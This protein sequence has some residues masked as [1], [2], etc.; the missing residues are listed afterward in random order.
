M[1]W[2]ADDV[3][4]VFFDAPVFTAVDD[5]L[6]VNDGGDLRLIGWF[7]DDFVDAVNGSREEFTGG[8]SHE[9]VVEGVAGEGGGPIAVVVIGV[10]IFQVAGDFSGDSFDGDGVSGPDIHDTDRTGD[11]GVALVKEVQL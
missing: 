7:F 4:G 10:E 9:G 3:A 11:D 8:F 5:D 6:A 2:G 1:G